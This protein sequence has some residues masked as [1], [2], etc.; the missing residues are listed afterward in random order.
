MGKLNK[1]SSGVGKY[2][3][4]YKEKST[5]GD[6]PDNHQQTKVQICEKCGNDMSVDKHEDGCLSN[7]CPWCG[8]RKP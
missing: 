8:T 6:L 3:K 4:Y 2:M 5:G 7:Y 1:Q